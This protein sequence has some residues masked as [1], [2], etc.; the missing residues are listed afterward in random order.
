MTPDD[1]RAD[2]D[3]LAETCE[4]N[5]RQLLLTE[6]VVMQMYRHHL[7][8]SRLLMDLSARWYVPWRWYRY[9]RRARQLLRERTVMGVSAD[10]YWA[11]CMDGDWQGWSSACIQ[12][13]GVARDLCPV[14][15]TPVMEA[16]PPDRDWR[17]FAPVA[18]VIGF[19]LLVLVL[20]GIFR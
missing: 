17:R 5:A 11:R 19:A 9:A 13:P 10:V 2:Y 4:G 12:Y 20:V 14:C 16:L 15:W 6:H 8:A 7:A 1:L 18:A 3:R